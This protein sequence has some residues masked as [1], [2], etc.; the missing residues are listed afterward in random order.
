M[1]LSP[2]SVSLCRLRG[3]AN[4]SSGMSALTCELATLSQPQMLTCLRQLRARQRPAQVCAALVC[5]GQ[6]VGV[7][8]AGHFGGVGGHFGGEG[9]SGW[10][11]GRQWQHMPYPNPRSWAVEWLNS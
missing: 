10:G 6:G 7:V 8:A 9:R 1:H 5:A 4:V 3:V 11:G 2:P